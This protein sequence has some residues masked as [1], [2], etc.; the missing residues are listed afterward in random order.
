MKVKKKNRTDQ[1][2]SLRVDTRET[3][4]IIWRR[5]R[6]RHIDELRDQKFFTSIVLT[7][8][9]TTELTKL[10]AQQSQQHRVE[11]EQHPQQHRV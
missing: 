11:M 10:L 6:S 2:V 1:R 3:Q 4:Q 8:A 7:M 5:R 9:E